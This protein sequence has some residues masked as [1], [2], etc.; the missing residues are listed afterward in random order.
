MTVEAGNNAAF[1]AYHNN[2]EVMVAGALG[3]SLGTVGLA[4]AFATMVEENTVE[5]NLGQA[6][7][8]AGAQAMPAII[9]DDLT[10][11]GIHVG[12]ETVQSATF[13]TRSPEKAGELLQ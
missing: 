3:A 12:A 2:V 9:R 4:G 8:S 10:I 13:L 1:D 7:V 11:A 5:T 6:V